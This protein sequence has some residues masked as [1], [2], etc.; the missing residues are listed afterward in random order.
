MLLITDAKGR[1]PKSVPLPTGTETFQSLMSRSPNQP[2][3]L[4][5]APPTQPA[6]NLSSIAPSLPPMRSLSFAVEHKD[7]LVYFPT[8]DG[9]VARRN[10]MI[11]SLAENLFKS[12]GDVFHSLIRTNRHV[13]R[14]SSFQT[15]EVRCT[16]RKNLILKMK[17]TNCE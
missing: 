3:S 14:Q 13:A 11:P 16:W 17:N 1:S 10:V 4:T 8:V 12:K 2:T 9:G 7:L 5:V 6:A 15:P